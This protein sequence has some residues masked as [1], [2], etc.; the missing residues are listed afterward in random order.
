MGALPHAAGRKGAKPMSKII[1]AMIF[2][3][4][5]RFNISDLAFF[6][7]TAWLCYH[8]KW[9][10]VIPVVITHAVF[11]IGCAVA[12]ETKIGKEILQDQTNQP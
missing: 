8:E 4:K 3:G 7:A 6:S 1:R 10:W 9:W 2:L 5:E 11:F 12:W